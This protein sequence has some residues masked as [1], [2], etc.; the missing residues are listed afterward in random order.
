EEHNDFCNTIVDR[1]IPG[2]PNREQQEETFARLGYSDKLLLECESYLLWAIEG[3]ERVKQVLEFAKTDSRVI[4]T[5]DIEPYREQ[6][7][8][9]LNGTH[10]FSVPLA[11]ACGLETVYQ[12]VNDPLIARFMQGLMQEEIA[13]TLEGI[14]PDPSSYA[15]EVFA[16][17]Q[18]PH[19]EHK[20]LNIM[21]QQ[22]TKMKLRNAA[23]IQ[24]Y[25]NRFGTAPRHM[26]LGVAAYLFFMRHAG[27]HAVQDDLAAYFR[28]LWSGSSPAQ[29]VRE[30]LSKL[31][32]TEDESQAAAFSGAVLSF[33]SQLL[34]SDPRRVLEQ[35]LETTPNPL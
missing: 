9:L 6:K 13:P 4:I 30:A 12:S 19:I 27:E 29:V 34:E 17:F 15:K 20:L 10:T 16:R 26:A 8:R 3:N 2:K 32:L 33:L 23:T 18:N 25:F 31:Q 14:S 22:S 11:F 5:G 35:F 7:L 21:F 28:E 1:I 24:R